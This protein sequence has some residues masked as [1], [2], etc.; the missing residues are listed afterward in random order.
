MC[1]GIRSA[2]FYPALRPR[3]QDR[4]RDGSTRIEP[5]NRVIREE[6]DRDTEKETE[7]R[8]RER[9]KKFSFSHLFHKKGKEWFILE[10]DRKHKTG[11]EQ[12]YPVTEYQLRP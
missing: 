11:L 6:R 4:M 2:D 9:A 5:V 10:L 12:V 3:R 7:A 1:A 8:V